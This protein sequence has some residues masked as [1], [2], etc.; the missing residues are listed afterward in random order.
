MRKKF[1]LIVMTAVLSAGMILGG[2]S[3]ST[4]GGDMIIQRPEGYKDITDVNEIAFSVPSY[5][6]SQ[7]TAITKVDQDSEL[8]PNT[9]YMYSDGGQS[10]LLFCM[11]QVMI[12]VQRDTGFNFQ[13]AED[14]SSALSNSGILNIWMKREGKKDFDYQDVTD[15]SSYKIIGTVTAEAV[16]TTDLF[17]DYVGK[18]SVISNGENEWGLF[19]GVPG[20]KYDELDKSKKEIIT[21]IVKSLRPGTAEPEKETEYA[22][23]IGT[24]GEE[25]P[26]APEDIDVAQADTSSE[27]AREVEIVDV[28]EGEN[29]SSSEGSFEAVTEISA[30]VPEETQEEI[31][32]ET[33]AAEKEEPAA[34]EAKEAPE[35]NLEVEI[36][37][38]PAE[39]HATE[40]TSAEEPVEETPREKVDGSQEDTEEQEP[41]EEIIAEAE[42][43]EEPKEQEKAKPKQNIIVLDNQKKQKSDVNNAYYSDIYSMVN[44]GDTGKLDVKTGNASLMEC[45]LTLNEIYI[46]KTAVKKLNEKLGIS[47]MLDLPS[48]CA[49]S[50]AKC[51]INYDDVNGTPTVQGKFKGL[52]GNNIRYLGVEYGDRVYTCFDKATKSGIYYYY[53]AV[54]IG[55]KDYCLVFGDGNETNGGHS[56]YF[57]VKY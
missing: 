51:T 44:I 16:I 24:S 20:S 15:G 49:W 34:G 3:K 10:F 2:C 45:R 28:G 4:N 36:V 39:E 53:Y 50:V 48:G 17:G 6:S 46:G 33:K 56:A 30:D 19:V 47:Q 21:N 31:S 22:V 26:D 18:M 57:H 52:D 29:N 38:V 11:N 13:N 27:Y 14:K 9:L 54:P 37:E 32:E 8:D 12:A 5:F 1:I 40:E 43:K 55:C 23:Q 35:E 41:S 42:V 7:A 25:K